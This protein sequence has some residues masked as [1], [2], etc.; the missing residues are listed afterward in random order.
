M[1]RLENIQGTAALIGAFETFD[2]EHVV[3][4]DMR[5]VEINGVFDLRELVDRLESFG[6]RLEVF[7]MD[8]LREALEDI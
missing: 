6:A 5:N 1:N 3:V 7:D 8:K 2:T 4:E